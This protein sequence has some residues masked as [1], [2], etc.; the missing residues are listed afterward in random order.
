MLDLCQ[1]CHLLILIWYSTT[2]LSLISHIFQNYLLIV[3]ATVFGLLIFLL[4]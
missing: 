2:I 1:L 4:V 3:F